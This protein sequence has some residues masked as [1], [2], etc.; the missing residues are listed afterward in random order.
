[1]FELILIS[2]L[3]LVD[4]NNTLFNSSMISNEKDINVYYLIIIFGGHLCIEL[5]IWDNDFKLWDYFER[6]RE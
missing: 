6:Q 4:C 2:Y 1:M 3:L 5:L